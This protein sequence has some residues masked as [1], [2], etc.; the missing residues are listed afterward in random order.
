LLPAAARPDLIEA[1][2][3][4]HEEHWRSVKPWH[5]LSGEAPVATSAELLNISAK[6]R[7]ALVG[8]F[9]LALRS[10]PP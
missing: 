5:P 2:L 8:R 7:S 10:S 4:L 6:V 1:P 9:L 3:W